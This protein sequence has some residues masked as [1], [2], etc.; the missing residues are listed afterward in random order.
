[1]KVLDFGIAKLGDEAQ[2]STKKLTQVGVT[3]GTPSYMSPEQAV[4]QPVDARSDVYS[5]GVMLYEMLTGRRPFEAELPVQV[6][7]MH[8][9]AEP[10]PLR[11]VAP[12]ARIPAALEEVVLRALAKR[13]EDRF[14]SADDL[15]SALGRAA[16]APFRPA[17]SGFAATVIAPSRSPRAR[18]SRSS[19]M[20]PAIIVLSVGMLI[21]SHALKGKAPGGPRRAASSEAGT[22]RGREVPSAARSTAA[23]E[24]PRR[25]P[26][27]PVAV[28]TSAAPTRR[29]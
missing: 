3:L 28:G 7:S 6:L 25:A 22:A 1:V 13:P 4:G 20:A 12:E 17:V 24:R 9:N 10:K 26:V 16:K 29:K 11:A 14:Q 21:A 18:P 5:C 8:L 27:T 2:V 19:W 23:R 15:R